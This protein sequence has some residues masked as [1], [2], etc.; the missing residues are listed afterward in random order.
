MLMSVVQIHLSPPKHPSVL[1]AGARSIDT[2]A[3]VL[4]SGF[5]LCHLSLWMYTMNRCPLFFQHRLRALLALALASVALTLLVPAAAQPA[6]QRIP[7]IP[8]GAA[9]GALVVTAPPE[10]LLD[11]KAA[12]LSPGARIHGSNNLLL[13]SASLVGQRLTVRYVRDSLGLVH[14]VWILSAAE[15]AALAQGQP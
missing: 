9:S 7:P 11:G 1:H 12:R 15:A 8:R 5:L 10:V 6:L 4:H 13:L 3:T 2:R 14:E